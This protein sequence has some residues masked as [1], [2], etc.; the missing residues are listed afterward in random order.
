MEWG[1]AQGTRTVYTCR[2][3]HALAETAPRAAEMV[4]E[5]DPR[6]WRMLAL[7]ALAELFGMS[8][9]FAANAVAPQL[10]IRWGLSPGE[11]GW[12][13]TVVQLGFVLGTALAALLNLADTLSSRWYFAGA[14]TAA[15]AA[16]VALLMAPSYR[17]ALVCRLLTGMCLAGVYPPAMKMAATWFLDRRG[18]A[19]GIV[20]GAL[21]IGKAVPYLVHAI[22]G[23]GVTA[24]HPVRHAGPDRC[25][26]SSPAHTGMAQHHFHDAHLRSH[27][28][29]PSCV[30]SNIG[31][32]SAAIQG[33]CWSCM[34]AGS[35]FPPF[36][37][38]VRLLG[39][40]PPRRQPAG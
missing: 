15:A 36:W 6:R 12:L 9:W 4:A 13:S 30:T 17:W 7:I 34:P 3:M 8:V 35:G 10:A 23:A 31:T 14:A 20:V 11:T 38:R 32:C 22:P 40:I 5:E 18:L 28:S 37:L 16:N 27:S 19:I 21:T 39:A 24:G 1:E 25:R 33:T 26:C 29:A 2:P